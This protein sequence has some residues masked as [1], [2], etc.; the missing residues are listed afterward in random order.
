[1]TS[2]VLL[3]LLTA[4]APAAAAETEKPGAIRGTVIHAIT[5]EPVRRAD[6]TLQPMMRPGGSGGAGIIIAGGMPP[7][8]KAVTD[9]EGNF[10]FTGVT[11]GTY[12]LRAERSGFIPAQ[13]GS[14]GRGAPGV[15]L[16]VRAGQELTGL[17]IEM[18]PQAVISGRVF[19]EEGE[20]MP[21]VMVM[22]IH[23]DSAQSA[24]R[25]AGRGF[26]GFGGQAQTDDRG[27]FRLH[28]L[29]PGKYILQVT[30]GRWG[31]APVM[32]PT[33]ES[34]EE[35]G[36]VN[37]YYPGVTDV[38]QATKLSAEAGAEISGMDVRL[39]RLRVFRV[40]GQ[41]LDPLG[42]PAKNYFVSIMPKGIFF[43]PLVAQQFYPMPNGGFE[44]R[45]L[46]PGS[47]RVL[48]RS[49]MASGDGLSYTGELEMGPQDVEGLILRLQTPVSV[50]GSVSQPAEQ[51]LDLT[52][53]RVMLQGD[54]PFMQRTGPP[55]VKDDGTFEVENVPPGK[56][57]LN[58]NVPTGGYIESIHYGDLDVTAGEFEVTST[59]APV[60]VVVRP[61]GATVSGVLLHDGKPAAGL[62]Y[63]IPADPARRSQQSVRSAVPD[64]TGAFTLNN[65]RPGDYLAYALAEADW[66]IWDDP[67]EFRAIESKAKKLS[68]KATSRESIELTLAK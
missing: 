2:L 34:G 65:L 37:T 7:G 30:P 19:D 27:Q 23:A 64:Q 38:A 54:V 16:T 67:D 4:Q 31:G 29:A 59:P 55:L 1:M 48:V 47:Y 26:T 61:G 46:V 60:R 21:N 44:I 8:A 53:M 63:L 57:R 51:K 3:T 10:Q 52:S 18:T 66:G 42:Q 36:Y 41:V 5:K 40:R 13:Y 11:P 68:L 39:K 28:N 12:F 9:A 35:M 45:N 50:K 43:G 20:P 33:N 6:V 17:R 49:N 56:Y 24:P 15:Q 22:A 32:G 25:R 62:V 58:L 14:R